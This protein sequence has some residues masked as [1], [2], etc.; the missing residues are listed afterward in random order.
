MHGTQTYSY[1]RQRNE[2]ASSFST[3]AQTQR[4]V[5]NTYLQRDIPSLRR[6]FTDGEAYTG[7]DIF[8]SIPFRGMKLASEE[9]MLPDSRH[10]FAPEITGVANANAQ[11]TVF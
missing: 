8:Y 1:N 6:E 4:Q 11:V 3:P 2:D 10:G 9:A 5:S 7:G